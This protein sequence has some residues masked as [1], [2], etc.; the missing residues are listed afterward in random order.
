MIR[1]PFALVSAAVLTLAMPLA[2]GTAIRLDVAGLVDRAALVIEG[3]VVG[4]RACLGPAKRIDTEYTIAV[5]HTFSGQHLP[6]R[7]VRLPGGVLPDGRG[8]VVPGIAQLSVGSDVLLFLTAAD[9]TNMR[10]PVGLAQGELAVVLDASGKKRIARDPSGLS[11]VDARTG[12]SAEA[13][14][15]S[16]LDYTATVAEIE[17]RAEAKRA[18]ES[19]GAD[20]STRARRGIE[21][22]GEK[23]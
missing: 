11:L 2:A 17:V 23:R 21:P 20:E 9:A 6:T 22:R 14:E 10:M 19:S 12:A 5:E 13:A 8:M 18:R 7:T 4:A 3:R 16:F 1:F 15:K